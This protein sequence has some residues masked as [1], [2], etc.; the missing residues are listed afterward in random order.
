MVWDAHAALGLDMWVTAPPSADAG[1]PAVRRQYSDATGH[2]PPLREDAMLFWQSRNRYKSTAIA[3]SVADQYEQLKLPIG[4][5]VI[6]TTRTRNRTVISDPTPLATHSC[7]ANEDGV[8][9][10][11]GHATAP[12]AAGPAAGGDEGLPRAAPPRDSAPPGTVLG[13][14]EN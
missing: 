3:L 14:Q 10:Q 7:A 4:V 12:G 13:A 11:G 1:L 6:W 2:A 9:L 5:L 8:E